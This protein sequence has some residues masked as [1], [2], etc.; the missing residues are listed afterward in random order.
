MRSSTK[1][2]IV[3]DDPAVRMSIRLLV[4]KVKGFSVV[5]LHDGA[6]TAIC[7]IPEIEP[8]I[9]FMDIR[10]PG[11]SGIECTRELKELVP[12]TKVLMLTGHVTDTLI[13]DAFQAGATGYLM[14]PVGFDEMAHVLEFAKK[15]D[16]YL[17]GTVSERF[18]KW[19]RKRRPKNRN[20]LT[21]R[22]IE[23]LNGVKRG[24]S[25]R[26]I[27]NHLGIKESTTKSHVHHILDKLDARSRTHAVS[28][29]FDYAS[30]H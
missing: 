4:D 5:S 28:V 14:K 16:I 27:A 13:A 2:S 23:V 21:S 17:T 18:S 8:D 20:T 24:W 1:V 19:M 15:G 6:E 9:V 12:K 25:D 30:E 3:D 10:M 29:F 22:E 7:G 26:E 11:K